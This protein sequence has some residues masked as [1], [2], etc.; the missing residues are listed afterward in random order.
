METP[1]LSGSGELDSDEI[2]TRALAAHRRGDVAAAQPDYEVLLARDPM[3]AGVIHLMGLVK[4]S[5][6]EPLEGER[7]IRQALALQGDPV[8][9][10]NLALLLHEMERD[11]E[12]E[13]AYLETLR[14]DP[15][16]TD[17]VRNHACFLRDRDRPEE[18]LV[19]F[20][21]LI[22]LSPGDG[23]AHAE[24]GVVLETLG[25]I[26]EAERAYRQALELSP[27]H[28]GALINISLS[29]LGRGDFAQG[30][31][32][33]ERRYD[34][35]GGDCS[36]PLAAEC[37]LW[38]GEP[39]AGRHLVAYGE[40]GFGDQIQFVRYAQMAK[41]SGAARVTAVVAPELV[42]LFGHVP[43]LDAVVSSAASNPIAADYWVPMMTIPSL[44]GV[45][46]NN[47]GQ[48]LPPDFPQFHLP[49]PQRGGSGQSAGAPLNVGVFWAGRVWREQGDGMRRIDALRS[50]DFDLILPLLTSKVLQESVRWTLL[51]RDRRPDG[52]ERL[53]R[54]QGWGDPF[55]PQALNAP[56]DFLDAARIIAE[57][58][59]VI[60]V[61]SAL[62]H[63]AAGL[64][65][66][67]WM[68]DR[69]AHCWR[70][71]GDREDSDWYPTLRIFRQR[72]PGAWPDVIARMEGCL[73]EGR[74]D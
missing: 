66:P 16:L 71:V 18:A 3:H 21:R 54:A 41:R 65:R 2:L 60:G 52:I 47:I 7:L 10:G 45:T 4:Q 22:E 31:R 57:L 24:R 15:S 46:A 30:W 72:S 9:L 19:G 70:W 48:S 43:G 67:T 37:R 62:I 1:R 32:F 68:M 53:A 6:G 58:D 44:F 33:Y 50:L 29:L 74:L 13:A 23:G 39:L 64:G 69:Y 61:D 20:E 34:H 14:I 51:Q 38:R 5:L 35:L 55:D 59:L 56:Q 11:G 49:A 40:Q 42:R 63:L 26:E 73:A 27:D 12:A 17:V 25:R 36:P 8:F 28:R